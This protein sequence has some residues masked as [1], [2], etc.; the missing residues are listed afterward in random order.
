MTFLKSDTIQLRA[1]E[2]SDMDFMFH[3]E[4]DTRLW[5][6]S[7]CKV[8]Y[9]RYQLQQYVETN[10]HDLYVDKQVRL[11]IDDVSN[12]QVVGAIDLFDFD[13]SNHRAEVGVV[14]E[15]SAR[16]RGF[17]QD[18]LSLV[19][20]YASRMLALHQLY[21]YILVDNEAAIRLFTSCGFTKVA[22]LSEWVMVEG[23]YKD[24]YIYQRIFEK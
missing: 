17:A 3:I 23:V 5:T 14:I 8:P 4:N 18:A 11:M 1:P 9:S 13:P 15:R 10:A 22:L 24:V 20:S 2:L 7:A 16:G 19:C 6:V 21:A 12:N